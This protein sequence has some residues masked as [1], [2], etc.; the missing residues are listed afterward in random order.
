M[1]SI[2]SPKLRLIFICILLV[3]ITFVA[4]YHPFIFGGQMYAYKD[5]GSDT[6]HQYLPNYAVKTDFLRHGRG[7]GYY[8]QSGL[9]EYV[10]DM[11]TF[12]FNPANLALL[13]FGSEKLHVGLLVATYIKYILICLFSLL[14]FLRLYKNEK[15]AMISA[16]L[17]TFSSYNVLWGQHYQFL[18]AIV[19]FSACMYGFQLYLE[20]DKYWYIAVPTLTLLVICNYYFTYITAWFLVAYGILYLIIQKKSGLFILKKVGLFALLA[21]LAACISASYLV[22]SAVSF[23]DSSRTDQVENAIT[24]SNLFYP[25]ATLLAFAARFLSSN[26]LGCGNEFTGPV[27]YYEAAILSVSFLFIYSVVY[28]LQGK[29]RWHVLGLLGGCILLLCI[30]MTSQLL[31]FTDL[32]QR[33]SFFLCFLQALTIGLALTEYYSLDESAKCTKRSLLAILIGDSL[34][35]LL[36]VVLICYHYHIGGSW[37][38]RSAC[39]NVVIILLIYHIAFLLLWKSGKKIGILLGLIAV[40]LV[41]SN[42]ATINNR[43]TI[44]IEEWYTQLYNDGTQNVVQWIK[45]QDDS[46]YRINK[47]YYSVCKADSLLQGYNGMGSYKS[48]N[49][50]HLI[51][52]AKKWGDTSPGNWVSFNG[53]DWLVNDLL[54]VKY[55]ISKSNELPPNGTVERIYDDGTYC[56]YQNLDWSGFGYLCQEEMAESS[57]SGLTRAQQALL[58]TKYY[59]RT[60][61]DNAPIAECADIKEIDLIPYLTGEYDC[62][63]E[64]QNAGLLISETGVDSQLYFKVPE[65]DGW[66]IAGVALEMDTDVSSTVQ[67]FAAAK[68]SNYSAEQC[69]TVEYSADSLSCLL[70]NPTDEPVVLRLDPTMA[71]DQTFTLHSIR[72]IL[73]NSDLLA[74]QQ[75]QQRESTV[76]NL[77]QEGNTFTGIITNSTTADAML[78]M[79]LIY[80]NLWEATLNGEKAEVI[81]INSGLVGI[82]IPSGTYELDLHFDDTIY[83]AGKI[84]SWGSITLYF[85]LLIWRKKHLKKQIAK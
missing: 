48:T 42:Y 71:A 47:T 34:L 58:L 85:I 35:A 82:S 10:S 41:L 23:F 4:L 66:H 30:P 46:I 65:T 11:L 29:Y 69:Y 79:P 64:T 70:D 83:K 43:G 7:D 22:S 25:I 84:V 9:G 28:L 18:S 44:T 80:S 63:V 3:S 53:K 31:V 51:D 6:I 76:S 68:D 59:Y 56:V 49:S 67:L 54:G 78:C 39:L 21:L 77:T 40:E 16:L 81:N 61:K 37:L 74:Q 32:T 75:L 27:N 62:R 24:S 38:N 50:K 17:W 55:I 8:L 45:E 36:G 12:F 33:W 20:D 19:G 26:L 15:A 1:G 73:I 13:I 60:D 72:L 57:L 2:R 14:F 52:L 5:I